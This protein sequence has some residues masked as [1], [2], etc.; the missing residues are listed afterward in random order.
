MRNI[1]Y[2]ILAICIS[3]TLPLRAQEDTTR[4]DYFE[5]TLEELLNIPISSAS[6]FS[7]KISDAPSVVSLINQSQ[8]QKYGWISIHDIAGTLPGFSQSKDYD[9][10]TLSSRGLYEGWNNNHLL[11]LVDGVPVNDNLYG[12][13]YTWEI[14]PLVFT[15]SLE[16]IR[17]PGSALYGSNAT[18]GVV[19][20]NTMNPGDLN[21]I[22]TARMRIGSRG[23]RI[24]DAITGAENDN[25]SI[26]LAFN[27]FETKGNEYFSYDD[28]RDN[29]DNYLTTKRKVQDGRS[30]N[31]IFAKIAAKGALEGLSVQYHEQHWDFQTG[32]GWLF[33]IP[34]QPESMKEFRRLISLKYKPQNLNSNF[35]YEF[36]TR[37][38]RHGL[39]WN[40]RY[41][42]DGAFDD[43]YPDGVTEYLKTHADDL[44]TRAQVNYNFGSESSLL[45]GIEHTLFIYNGD[46]AHSSNIDLNNTYEANPGNQFVAANPWFEFI[47]GKPVNTVGVFGQYISPKMGGKLQATIGA[48]FDTQSFDYIDI[49][50]NDQE[51]S[52]SFSQFSPRVGLVFFANESLTFKGLAGRAFRTPAP[53]EMFGA[54]TY[55]LASNIGELEPELITTIE[56]AAD[57]KLNKQFNLRI[58]SFYTDF[59][60]QIA[61]SVA[62]ANLSTNIYSLTSLGSELELLYNINKFSGFFNY[63]QVWRQDEE[64]LDNTITESKDEVTWVPQQTANLGITYTNKKFYLSSV[65]H[66]QGEVSRR[67]SDITIETIPFRPQNLDAW[68]EMDLKVAYTPSKKIEVGILVKN[69]FN[70]ENYLIK[71]NA[72]PFDYRRPERSILFDVKVNL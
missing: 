31:Y 53:T 56:F 20:I 14:T 16:I 54:N 21:G 63:S 60:N 69:L 55:S 30:S 58:N 9:R 37:Y 49:Y 3:S 40:M 41:Y 34:D 32:H 23:T 67:S 50:N 13:A 19:T 7:Q 39:D 5:L 48:R 46:D 1:Y 26:L 64:I 12:T 57:W 43:F 36:M 18:N 71:N 59:E 72:Y 6:K 45:A 2:V 10:R 25:A 8:I 4:V 33:Y 27:S 42:S 47:D 28:T 70:S 15:K 44:L 35:G 22:G 38:Q 17:G 11:M 24:Y 61:Y 65:V 62:N 66:Y 51:E 29:G 68:A 52:K